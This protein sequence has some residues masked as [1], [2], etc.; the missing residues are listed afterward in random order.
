MVFQPLSGRLQKRLK[1][2]QSSQ[3]AE[4]KIQATIVRFLKEHLGFTGAQ[5]LAVNY[6][7]KER[8]VTLTLESKTLANDL[9]FRTSQLRTALKEAGVVVSRISIR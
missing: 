5:R 8:V 7:Q 1:L 4:K 2:L 3:T 6:E 9:L